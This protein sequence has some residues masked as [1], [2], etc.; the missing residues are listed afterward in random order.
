[1]FQ[2]RGHAC[3]VQEVVALLAAPPQFASRHL[4]RH[5][6]IQFRIVRKIDHT[7]SAGTKLTTNL[8]PADVLR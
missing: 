1:M 5:Q 4:Q 3:L 8:E 7:K 6:P 2:P